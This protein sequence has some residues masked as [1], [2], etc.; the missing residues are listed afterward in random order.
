MNYAEV[1]LPVPLNVPFTYAIPASMQPELRRGMRVIVPFGKKKFYTGIVSALVPTTP[2]GIEI[3]EIAEMPDASPVVRR[4]QL[5]FWKWI[6]DYYLSSIGDVM[7]AALPAGLKVESETFVE[8]SPDYEGTADDFTN[9][10]EALFFQYVDHEGKRTSL[11]DI[12][13]ATGLKNVAAIANRLLERGSV[14]IAE[15]LVERY[16][17]QKVTFVRINAG[18]D[19]RERVRSFF[20]LVSRARKQEKAFLTLLALTD[21]NRRD[22]ELKEVTVIDLIEKSEVTRPVINQLAKRG[23]VEIYTREL[24]RFSF[25]GLPT[26]VMPSLSQAQTKALKEVHASWL[27]GNDITLLHGVT[28]SGKTEIYCHL[29]DY[30][31]RQ[32]RQALFL[33]P[34]IALTTQ[35]TRR[36]Q[37]IFG[38]KVVIYHSKF[39]DNERVDIWKRMLDDSRPCVVIGARSSV[40]LPFADL[41]LVIVDEEHES[42]YKQE[43]PAPRYNARDAS[44]ILARMHGAKVLL[45]SA[46]PSVETF[47]KALSGRY[48]LVSLAERYGGMSLPKIEIIDTLKARKKGEMNG[49]FSARA[50][51]MVRRALDEGRQAIM[52]LNRRGYAPVA[53]CKMCAYT[54][55]CDNCDVTLT[56]HRDID[57]MVCH[58]CGA[59]YPV[60]RICPSCR[61]PAVEVFG[62]GTERIEDDVEKVFPDVA[63][64]RMDLDTT[65]KKDGYD[66]LITEFSEGRSRILVGTQM[67]TKGLDF[68]GVSVVSV[69]NADTLLNMPDFRASE[70]AFN[71]LE[72]VAGRAGRRDREG[73]VAIQTRQPDNPVLGYVAAHDYRGFYDYEIEERRKFN[74][75]PFTRII[76][77]Y[78]RHRDRRCVDEIAVAWTRRLHELF[79]NRVFGPEEPAVARV[80]LLYIRKIMLK[81]EVNASMQKVKAILRS[82][83][84]EMMTSP[85]SGIKGTLIAYDVD[86]H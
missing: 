9:E 73:V 39:T 10:R 1:I 25:E 65:R 61:E 42:S 83:Y 2:E 16:R 70:R 75:P 43:N 45:G 5:Q 31:L 76:Y 36:L 12:A 59:V 44:M 28:S 38:D 30:T 67:V 53:E 86:P 64:S 66:R 6:A 68:D 27:G 48:G 26:G 79:G 46:T 57:R 22:S 84:E 51:E 37:R 55:K 15:K 72:Q 8:V 41:G 17:S 74:Y 62:Y 33:V 34:E 82:L 11:S 19:D 18:R 3:K 56:Y 85:I 52:F 77:I 40:F 4:P 29:I 80:Q 32:G 60:P 21:F 69:L 50:V 20:E 23:I 81:V 54:P 35:L 14:I 24:N 49:I 47:F 71:M 13:K 7:R 78:V 58:Y 63:V